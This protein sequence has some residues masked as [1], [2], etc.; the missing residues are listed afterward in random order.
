LK[1]AYDEGSMKSDK[2]NPNIFIE[3]LTS[4][5]PEAE[6]SEARLAD[7]ALSVMSGGTETVA[8]SK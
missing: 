7:E 3:L 8:W 4:T 5:L 6:K 2:E 1:E